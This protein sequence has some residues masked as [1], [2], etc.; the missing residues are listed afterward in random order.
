MSLLQQIHTWKIEK[1]D[2]ICV[3]IDMQTKLLPAMSDPKTVEE[4]V[5]RLVQGM[6]A[7]GIPTVVTQQYTKASVRRFRLWQRRWAH[8]NRSIRPRSAA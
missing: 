2:A 1:D 4:N 6:K 3:L 8:L 7:L 5:I